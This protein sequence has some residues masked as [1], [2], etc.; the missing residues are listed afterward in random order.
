LITCISV[1]I[2][3]ASP[4][5]QPADY[6]AYHRQ[7]IQADQALVAGNYRAALAVMDT[8]FAQYAFVFLR[9]YQVAAQVA[10]YIGNAPRAFRY[11]RL[12]ALAGWDLTAIRKV[13]LFARLRKDPAWQRFAQEYPALHQRYLQRLDT[14]MAR[15]L[16]QMFGDDQRLAAENL[17]I[18]DEKAQEVFLLQ[19]FVPQNEAQVKQIHAMLLQQGYPGEKRIGNTVWASTILSHHNS[20]SPA[21]VRQDSLY[22]ALRPLLLQAIASGDLSPGDFAVIEDWR[23]VVGSDHQQSA[24]GYLN[25]LHQRDI[26]QSDSLR[27]AIG[28]PSVA[29]RNQLVDVQHKTGI[30][31]YLEGTMWVEGKIPI[32]GD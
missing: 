30:N 6:Q 27:A 31:F 3:T 18:S 24:Y 26:P 13:K 7:I 23:I 15:R 29:L 14:T 8:V 4:A 5:Q 32:Q 19:H 11:L 22:P 28:L 20:V 10:A 1:G 9:D 16:Q 17:K 12:A 2:A 25:P 21:Y